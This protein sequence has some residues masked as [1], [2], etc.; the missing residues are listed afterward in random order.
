MI[1]E[2]YLKKRFEAGRREKDAEWRERWRKREDELRA[3]Y[4]AN[5]EQLNGATPPPFL[6]DV[7]DD[8][9]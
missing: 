5:R 1:A 7:E 8:Q 9:P 4:E 2:A 3:W 6:Q